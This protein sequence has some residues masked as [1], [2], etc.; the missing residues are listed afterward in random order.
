MLFRFTVQLDICKCKLY[1]KISND[2]SSD[3]ITMRKANAIGRRAGRISTSGWADQEKKVQGHDLSKTQW[4]HILLF[5][6]SH[7]C[8]KGIPVSIV[9]VLLPVLVK[10]FFSPGK[11]MTER[12]VRN[13]KWLPC[14][15]Q[16]DTTWRGV[17]SLC[18]LV[19]ITWLL[20]WESCN[21]NSV[22]TVCPVGLYQPCQVYKPWYIKV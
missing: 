15:H 21:K 17:R 5:P 20:Y 6:F 11:S 19:S 4:T 22:F 13:E 3:L 8:W 16:M 7:Q 12:F 2:P 18:F 10:A 9:S 14:S 1:D